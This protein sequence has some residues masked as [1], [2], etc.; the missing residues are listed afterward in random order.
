MSKKDSKK[1]AYY[2]SHDSNARNDPKCIR[3][4]MEKGWEAYGL[5]WGIIEKLRDQ[6]DYRFHI[7]EIPLIAYEFMVSD[8]LINEIIMN[9]DLFEITKDQYFFSNRLYRSMKVMDAKRQKYSEWGKQGNEKRWAKQSPP[10]RHPIAIKEKEIKEKESKEKESSKVPPGTHTTEQVEMFNK[11]QNWLKEDFPRVAAMKLPITIKEYFKLKDIIPTKE[12][13]TEL[14]TAMEN[15][16]D[17]HKKYSSTFLT[18]K[19]WS[20]RQFTPEQKQEQ[21]SVLTALK[22][23]KAKEDAA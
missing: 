14:L 11:F 22:N 13:L 18:L 20:K 1:D 16:P 19:V 12:L 8:I 17:L 6:K 7:S 9:Y 21:G 10:D 3:L 4:R 23:F 5:F 15:R 2:F